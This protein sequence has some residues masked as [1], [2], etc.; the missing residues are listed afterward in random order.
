MA[1]CP[2]LCAAVGADP[3][4]A[5]L[6]KSRVRRRGGQEKIGYDG[7]VMAEPLSQTVREL[8]PSPGGRGKERGLRPAG[9]RPAYG[10]QR[11]VLWVCRRLAAVCSAAFRR[12]S[13]HVVLPGA[14]AVPGSWF[15]VPG[16]GED[17][18]AAASGFRLRVS[19]FRGRSRRRRGSPPATRNPE[20]GTVLFSP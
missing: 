3:C 1:A 5:R 20:P 12:S 6:S 2:I 18:H 9:I 15:Q 19:G 14:G 13:P 16:V 4:N 17:A 11:S 10:G 7:P 8:S